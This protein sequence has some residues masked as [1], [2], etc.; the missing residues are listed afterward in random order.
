VIFFPSSSMAVS[1]CL[2]YSF[3]LLS[4]VLGGLY[5]ILINIVNHRR[6]DK[7]LQTN[8]L[9]NRG[10]YLEWIH[11]RTGHST[12]G[13]DANG[14]CRALLQNVAPFEPIQRAKIKGNLNTIC[15]SCDK[16]PTLLPL[17][18]PLDPIISH[19]AKLSPR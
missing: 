14:I 17:K 8:F 16:H 15:N 6:S 3:H 9:H 12:A 19:N 5:C 13:K 4:H 1:I 11:S 18:H 2:L 10:A 7:N